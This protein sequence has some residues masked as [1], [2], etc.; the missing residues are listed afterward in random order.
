MQLEVLAQNAVGIIG[1]EDPVFELGDDP[2]LRSACGNSGLGGHQDSRA[3]ML[4]SSPAVRPE[5]DFGGAEFAG[6]DIDVSEPA[7]VPL[8]ATAAR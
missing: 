2:A 6:R 1:A 4:S 8:R 3:P 5:V 7:R